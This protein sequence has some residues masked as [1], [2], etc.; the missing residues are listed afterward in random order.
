M[1]NRHG[2]LH[3]N[4]PNWDKKTFYRPVKVQVYN[5]PFLGLMFSHGLLAR[6]RISFSPSAGIAARISSNLVGLAS[7]A[8]ADIDVG[9]RGRDGV[10]VRGETERRAAHTTEEEQEA[11]G[12]GGTDDPQSEPSQDMECGCTRLTDDE[13]AEGGGGSG[14]EKNGGGDEGHRDASGRKGVEREAFQ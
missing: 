2:K 9:R 13:E 7:L 14:D 10:G 6:L 11:D 4:N 3:K 12:S 5:A 1:K 8:G